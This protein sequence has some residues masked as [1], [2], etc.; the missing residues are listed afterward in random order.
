MNIDRL[1]DQQN[2]AYLLGDEKAWKAINDHLSRLAAQAGG[3][4]ERAGQAETPR[5]LALH[6]GQKP[7]A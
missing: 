5:P 7:Q 3:R 4:T 6:T 1:L 2:L